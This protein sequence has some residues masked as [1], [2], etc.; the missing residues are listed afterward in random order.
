MKR[1]PSTEYW[2]FL[3]K[4]DLQV[5]LFV[6]LASKIQV[7]NYKYGNAGKLMSRNKEGSLVP[8]IYGSD[9]FLKLKLVPRLELELSEDD[10]SVEYHDLTVHTDYDGFISL[11]KHTQY[12]A[13]SASRRL[14]TPKTDSK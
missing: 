13:G 9:F 2:A 4:Y 10:D 7:W 11:F 14:V 1:L 8:A 5:E 12:K 6:Q 3:E